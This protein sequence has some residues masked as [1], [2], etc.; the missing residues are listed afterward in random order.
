MYDIYEVLE[1]SV[2]D[3]LEKTL[4]KLGVTDTDVISSH[5]NGA[6]PT[7]T[8]I[9]V[10][11]LSVKRQG[12]VDKSGMSEFTGGQAKEYLVQP[13]E[14]LIQINFN[15]AKAGGLGTLIHSQYAS[16]TPV[17]EIFIRNN[18][19][20][21]RVSDLRRAPQLRDGNVFVNSFAMDMML[22]YTVRTVQDIDWAD[23]ITVNKETIPLTK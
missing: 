9:V 14:A 20:P 10:N 6:E 5:Q 17:R 1:E 18:L 3:S 21:R 16:N 4:V 15:G 22:G 23:Y 11:V 2:I 8:Y 19:A 7:G 12:R 13:Y